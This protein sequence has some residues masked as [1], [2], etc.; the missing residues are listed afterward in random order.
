MRRRQTLA[1]VESFANSWYSLTTQS[2]FLLDERA[3]V[4]VSTRAQFTMSL[5]SAALQK[6]AVCHA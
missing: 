6:A 4:F 5:S 3:Y 1:Q 2:L